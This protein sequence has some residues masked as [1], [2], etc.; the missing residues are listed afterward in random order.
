MTTIY[1]VRHGEYENPDYL[2]PGRLLDGYHLSERGRDQ[3]RKLAQYFADKPII[4]LYSSPVLRCRET[5][6]ILSDSLT[7]PVTVDERLLEVKTTAEGLSMKLFDETR[8]ELSY[9]PDFQ[10]KGAES[11]ESLANRIYGFVEEVRLSHAN[12]EVLIVTHGDVIAFGVTKYA[13]LSITFAA[14]RTFPTPLARGYRLE[15]DE[16]GKPVISPIV[17]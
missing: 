7:L 10:A 16:A 14:S 9:L 5:A 8:G 17:I 2:F 3:V 6:S 12:Q 11:M 4:S 1:L 15:F 13:G